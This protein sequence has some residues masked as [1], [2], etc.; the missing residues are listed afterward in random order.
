MQDRP[1]EDIRDGGPLPVFEGTGEAFA[2]VASATPRPV[3][4]L[5]VCA[6]RLRGTMWAAI[7]W[8]AKAMMPCPHW[9]GPGMVSG[10]PPRV[11]L[12]QSGQVLISASTWV[13]A[14]SKT[15]STKVRV[16]WP[17]ASTETM[18]R[19]QP[20][21]ALTGDVRVVLFWRR[22]AL[23]QVFWDRPLELG[24][25]VA[26]GPRQAGVRRCLLRRPLRENRDHQF[27]QEHDAVDEE[28]GLRSELALPVQGLEA[29]LV[30][31]DLR[32]QR[33]PVDGRHVTLRPPPP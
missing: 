6:T 21:H 2:P 18:E 1:R 29:D 16:S 3:S 12:P 26:A 7:W 27:H 14:T 31:L 17:E 15:M 9:S 28:G 8:M 11:S 23:S 24:G 22:L 13:V 19:P 30:V 33:G 25:P 32:A 20:E 5:R 10:K 4:A